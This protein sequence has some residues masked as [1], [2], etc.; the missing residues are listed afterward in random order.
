M[1]FAARFLQHPSIKAKFIGHSNNVYKIK[2]SERFENW[3][4]VQR[5]NVVNKVDTSSLWAPWQNG[6]YKNT[7]NITKQ[8]VYKDAT[9]IKK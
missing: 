3:R 6:P 5:N 2:R 7:Q 1:N 9:D 4:D 8:G